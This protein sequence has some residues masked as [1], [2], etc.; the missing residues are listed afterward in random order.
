LILVIVVLFPLVVILFGFC[1][2]P[3]GLSY[4][5][6][7]DFKRMTK[8]FAGRMGLWLAIG[9]GLLVPFVWVG[10]LAALQQQPQTQVLTALANPAQTA[11]ERQKL[12]GQAAQLRSGLLNAYL[13]KYRYLGV[14]PTNSNA[15]SSG[16][17]VSLY[18][19]TF[20]VSEDTAI[21]IQRAFNWLASPFLYQ[22]TAADSDKAAALYASFFDQPI[23]RAEP[24]A[25]AAAVNAT[26]DRTT[27]KAG[28]MD[29]NQQKVLLTQQELK[30]TPH[31]DWADIS[32]HE[33]YQNRTSDQQEVLYYFSLPESA[34]I[35]GLWLGESN[36]LS[37]RFAFAVSPR[38]AAQQVY[39]NQLERR[40]DPALL[41]QV[42]PGSYRLRAF[43]VLPL[44]E[45]PMHL[46]LTYK[47][48][49][50]PGGGWPLPQLNERRNI[51]WNSSTQ[52]QYNGQTQRG[53]QEAWFPT[54]LQT[55]AKPAQ[56]HRVTFASGDQLVAEPFTTT[57]NTLP[58]GKRFAV[59][60]D[61]SYSMG[62]QKANL[63]ET[64]NWLKTKV[65]PK[66]QL[67]LYLTS[68]AGVSPQRVLDFG[69]FDFNQLNFY[70]TL[71]PKQMLAQFL[72][73]WPKS[74]YDG[75]LLLTDQGSY[76][77]TDNSR[78]Q[79]ALPA[80]LWMVHLGGLAPAYDDDTQQAIKDSRGGVVTQV[81]AA[82]ERLQLR[83]Q[84]GKEVVSILDG[85]RW[86]R[87]PATAAAT[88]TS[89]AN[90][91]PVAARQLVQ[92][93]SQE[94][95]PTQ[96]AELDAIHAIAT[97]H[98]I[99][100]PYSSMI[101]LIN[102]QQRRELKEAENQDDRFNR[103]VEDQ[104]QLPKPGGSPEIAGVPEPQGW[105]LLVVGLGLLFLR[106]RL[107]LWWR[108]SP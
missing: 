60:I 76:E 46:W 42:G 12:L 56:T 10:S 104:Q 8:A 107:P 28:L 50:Q 90:F 98:K 48:L 67:E 40:V 72:K 43:P 32:I 68:A 95:Q 81:A 47:A 94:L 45:K 62:K 106:N 54:G 91:M 16:P 73:L 101:V 13:S 100:T 74:G 96:T 103:E 5:A 70:G 26:F 64:V 22:G 1:T 83:T 99:V 85:Y 7:R 41:E 84:T 31:G 88:P 33:V 4:L 17:L 71:Q 21:G 14:T 36:D 38:G 86:R 18:Q 97:E 15:T 44:G 53:Y 92:A 79:A 69:K 3:I 6:V 80:P 37:K 77:L 55:S 59:V 78:F 87:L 65:L 57:T 34:A 30:V 102:D 49:Q 52:R 105:L 61:T 29:I 19:Q 9:M 24:E 66:N 23:L 25:V 82:V 27:M 35:T 51:F 58:T 75:I 93:R 11:S 63:Q 39:S 89:G 20:H 2:M 108:K